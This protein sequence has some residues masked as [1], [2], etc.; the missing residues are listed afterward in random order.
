MLRAFCAK[1]KLT[2]SESP[3]SDAA[4]DQL[5]EDHTADWILRLSK[6]TNPGLACEV[7]HAL[8]LQTAQSL[9]DPQAI[10][11]QEKT[12]M[13]ERMLQLKTINSLQSVAP[14][15]I[16]KGLSNAERYYPKPALRGPSDLDIL[17]TPKDLDT[18]I[19]F[20]IDQGFRFQPVTREQTIW[21]SIAQHS[22]APLISQNG[23]VNIDLHIA[24]DAWPASKIM[25][26]ERLMQECEILT[27]PSGQHFIDI[28]V[29]SA[30]D[31]FLLILGN[32]SRDKFLPIS[33]K[34]L[35]DA[36]FLLI[37]DAARRDAGQA[38][39]LNWDRISALAKAGGLIKPLHTL[40][41]LLYTLQAP[42]EILA[43]VPRWLCQSK[44]TALFTRLSA[45]WASLT[46]DD[47]G[48][49]ETLQLE[50]HCATTLSASLYRLYLRGRGMITPSTGVPKKWK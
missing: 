11:S 20:F 47:I 44:Q 30:Q 6:V 23:L 46:L 17:I 13:L 12:Y 4:T 25:P 21:G 45:R 7:A 8:D 15:L 40:C 26:F 28:P 5:D 43:P 16:I 22:L 10:L 42:S 19:T 38:A 14:F 41:A 18:V 2:L 49:W 24:A 33:A 37:S 48:Q 29:V 50:W 9:L 39:L 34:K 32:L 27:L 36:I 3:H 1:A 31:A 35:F